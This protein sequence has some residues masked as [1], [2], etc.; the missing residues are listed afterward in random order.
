MKARQLIDA[1]LNEPHYNS[2][3]EVR[4]ARV[5]FNVSIENVEGEVTRKMG[6]FM[7][8]VHLDP[9]ELEAKGLTLASKRFWQGNGEW[10]LW[11]EFRGQHQKDYT[12]IGALI[13]DHY[14]V[15]ADVVDVKIVDYFGNPVDLQNVARGFI[16]GQLDKPSENEE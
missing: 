14:L 6:P 4:L 1:K 5:T 10:R 2:P 11:K 3:E 8:D 9:G 12:V 13:A 7:V 15:D 16:K